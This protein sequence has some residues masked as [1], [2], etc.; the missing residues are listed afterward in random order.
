VQVEEEGG[1]GD[2]PQTVLLN[3]AETVWRCSSQ[4][5][6]LTICRLVSDGFVAVPDVLLWAFSSASSSPPPAN[7]SNGE[8]AA[9]AGAVIPRIVAAD[10]MTATV[11]LETVVSLFVTSIDQ[12]EARSHSNLPLRYRVLHEHAVHIELFK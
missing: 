11:A 8:K 3:S 9:A 10:E 4:R 2:T 5:A 6:T 7:E 12:A 1:G